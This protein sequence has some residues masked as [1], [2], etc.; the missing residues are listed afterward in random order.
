MQLSYLFYEA[1]ESKELS[2]G[3]RI[4]WR[5]D[6]TLNDGS[7]V[8][9]DL[10]GGYFDAGDHVKFGQPMSFSMTTLAWGG[11]EYEQAYRT[12]LRS[13]RRGSNALEH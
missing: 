11:I 7:I 9:K 5:E 8:G 12:H 2:E 1:N 4:T 6:S 13:L 10:E 3:N